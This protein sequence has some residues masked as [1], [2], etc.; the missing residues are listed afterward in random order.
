METEPLAAQKL[1]HSLKSGSLLGNQWIPEE[2]NATNGQLNDGRRAVIL[3]LRVFSAYKS[4][5]VRIYISPHFHPTITNRVSNKKMVT[6]MIKRGYI[7]EKEVNKAYHSSEQL[8]LKRNQ[9]SLPSIHHKNRHLFQPHLSYD[10]LDTESQRSSAVEQRFRKPP[11][12]GSIPT[13]GS[14]YGGISEQAFR[15]T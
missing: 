5:S 12:V 11:V 7:Y 15:K 2:R 10:I 14:S 4:F 6:A 9:K 8:T 3:Q 13:A 1:S